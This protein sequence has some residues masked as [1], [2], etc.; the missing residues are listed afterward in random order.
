MQRYFLAPF[1]AHRGAGEP[2]RREHR[3]ARGPRRAA[4]ASRSSTPRSPASSRPRSAACSTTSGAGARPPPTPR[5]PAWWRSST[6]SRPQPGDEVLTKWRYSAFQRSDLAELLADAGRDQLLITGIYAHIGCMVTAVRGVHARRAAVPRGRRGRP[7]SPAPTTSRR[8]PGP[9]SAAASSPRPTGCSTRWAAGPTPWRRRVPSGRRRRDAAGRRHHRRPAHR[10]RAS[11]AARRTSTRAAR[12]GPS[13]PACCSSALV[14][15]LVVG[16]R[17]AAARRWCSTR[18]CTG[19][20]RPPT[21]TPSSS[22]TSGCHGP[23][24]AWPW[25]SRSGAAG[26]LM[27]ALTRNPLADPGVLGINWGASA[28]IV[29]GIL[30]LRHHHAQRLRVVLASPAPRPSP[31]LV[32]VLGASGRSGATPARLALAGTAVGASLQGVIYA[33]VLLDARDVRPVPG[34]ARRVADRPRPR[35]AG[36]GAAVPG[37]RRARSPSRS[38]APSTRWPSARTTGRAL[39]VRVAARPG[40]SPASA[41]VLLCGGATAAAGPIA[42]VGLAVPHLA[43]ADD[44][45]GPAL[46]RCRTRWCSAALLVVAAD[47]VGRVVVMPAPSSRSGW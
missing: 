7:T 1:A 18:C 27:Q 29:G 40:R 42:F 26:A 10:S 20:R 28:A 23:C 6:S 9:R 17:G 24:S 11:R 19:P 35:G 41:I 33:V 47:V 12:T 38:R 30:R 45:S 5:T 15:S 31:S 25:A 21:L 14:A 36:A 34:V 39:G 32:Y 13:R 43:R 4:S 46:G 37:P 2:L 3:R 8:S 44:R 16:S 22:S